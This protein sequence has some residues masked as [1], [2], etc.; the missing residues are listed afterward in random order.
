MN[1]DAAELGPLLAL[2]PPP[3]LGDFPVEN[4]EQPRADTRPT[5]KLRRPLDER[6]KGGLGDIFGPVWI[7]ASPPR[8][9]EN[10]RQVSVHDGL[11]R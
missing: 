6:R 9:P 8:R 3:R 10:L 1:P 5:F 11:D 4:S 2:K 7:E